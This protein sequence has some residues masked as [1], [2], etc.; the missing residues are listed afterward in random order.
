LINFC[1]AQF[2]VSERLWD[3][4]WKVMNVNLAM[5]VGD[6][7]LKMQ[8]TQVFVLGDLI[9][10]TYV[11][12]KVSRISPEAPVPV[13]LEQKQWAVL[14]GAANV[15]ANIAAFGGGVVLAGRIGQ[16]IDGDHFVKICE[17]LDVDCAGLLRSKSMPTTRK[18]RVMAGYQQV[19]RIDS[20]CTELLSTAEVATLESKVKDFLNRKGP[21]AIV[22]SDY[23]KGVC[24]A[25]LLNSVI[26]LANKQRV[27][28][29]TDPKSLDMKRYSGST[30]IKPNLSEG[31]E[32][33]KIAS[34]GSA[35]SSFDS[36]VSAVCQ[37][38]LEKSGAHNV[39]L[40]LSEK[41]VTVRGRDVGAGAHFETMALQVADVSGA[42]DTMVAFLAMG[43]AADIGMARSV[44]L[45]NIAAGIVCGKLGTATVSAS[46]FLDTFKHETEETKPEKVL[47]RDELAEILS[48]A[49]ESGKKIV[50][51]NGCFDLL[52][53]GHVEVLQK[54]K[55]FGDIL[56]VAINSDASVKK[57]KGPTRP[58]QNEEDRSR[59]MAALACVDY[60][61]IFEEETPAALISSFKPKILVKG[62]DYNSETI[63]GAKD[64]ASWGGRVEI[65]PLVNGRST[66]SLVDRAR[67]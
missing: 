46:E 21:K 35:Y 45:A 61:T 26:A 47:P 38:V 43:M 5:S 17:S 7:V 12:G 14:G 42:G 65:V 37:A 52:H 28:V 29:I 10:D 13:V 59:I 58:L 30:L 39:V 62:G 53:A 18:L 16:D 1:A 66:T 54:A 11:S 9:L 34:P 56:V 60:V 31:R 23:G 22:I 44:Q 40:S 24:T 4:V 51:T 63:V 3:G 57:L 50:F 67:S 33:L 64:V 20:E 41:G 8:G 48:Q 55:S 32:V 49:R 15:A 2:F 19:V 27:P 25:E 36:E 6:H